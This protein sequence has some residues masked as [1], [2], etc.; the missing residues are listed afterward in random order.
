MVFKVAQ[1]FYVDS[2]A[3][4]SAPQCTISSVTLF[5]KA[6][7]LATNNKSGIAYP[8]LQ[9]HLFPC[10]SDGTPDINT[11]IP[12]AVS[13]MEFNGITASADASAAT[14]FEFLKPVVVPTNAWYVVLVSADGDED[15][16]LWS[17]TEGEYYVGTNTLSSGANSKN[18]GDYYEYSSS[19]EP[20][21][22]QV[23][24]T[25]IGPTQ[26]TSISTWKPLKDVDLKFKVGVAVNI[27]VE[28]GSIVANSTNANTGNNV[29]YGVSYVLPNEPYEFM[30]Y[31]KYGFTSNNGQQPLDLIGVKVYQETP[32]TYG[33]LTVQSGNSTILSSNNINFN[34]LFDPTTAE[35]P[36][37]IMKDPGSGIVALRQIKEIQSNTQLVVIGDPGFTSNTCN[38]IVSPVAEIT[39][40]EEYWYSGNWW[41][42][43]ILQNFTEHALDVAVLQNSNANSTVRF[44]NNH[45]TSANVTA[46]GSGYSN[47]DYITVSCGVSSSLNATANIVTSNIG[48]ITGLAFANA[49]YG[50]INTASYSIFNANGAASSG[51]GATLT[52]QTGQNIKTETPTK[53]SFANVVFDNFEAHWLTPSIII[54]NSVNATVDTYQ[55]FSYYVY[56][57]SENT[58]N[59]LPTG[60]RVTLVGGNQFTPLDYNDGRLWVI[61]SRSNDVVFANTAINKTNPT[62]RVQSNTDIGNTAG[63]I[64]EYVIQS[65]NVFTVPCIITPDLHM[66]QYVI[67][68]DATGENKRNG[69][70]LA[71][72]VSTKI[73]F[74]RSREAEDAVVVLRARR[75]AG[76]D[77]KVYAKIYN[78]NDPESF[79]DKDWSELQV[80][81]NN[82][83]VTTSLTDS[84]SLVEFH[85]GFKPYPNSYLVCNTAVATTLNSN[86]VIGAVGSAFTG[87]FQVSDVVKIS[88]PLFPSNYQITTIQAV[89]NNSQIVLNDQVANNSIVGTN[90]Q[91]DLIGRVAN[92]ANA[93]IGL[94]MQAFNNGQNDNIVRYYNSALSE[95]DTYETFAIKIVLLSSKRNIVPMIEDVRALG[96]TT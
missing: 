96:V 18:I 62:T 65:N 94:P 93:E 42:G 15:F 74:D 54:I 70:A 19:V 8:G 39:S 17:C 64:S 59:K 92:G 21:A 63:S 61:P 31:D 32:V 28:P 41:N 88:S 53:A 13:A 72:H 35:N 50:F 23:S 46:P 36:Y 52:F 68:N 87:T 10:K 78:S 30:V 77:I 84:S 9:V 51:T 55:H 20:F 7:P 49:G 4:K 48:A 95:F 38:F 45:V 25:T 71:K 3:L 89:T 16:T 43:T 26:N 73:S 47:T 85:Y 66:Y 11:P 60:D 27:D 40:V 81:S 22:S 34:T 29:T 57:G 56:P 80:T 86:V 91:L 33:T 2:A 1:T 90:M 24:A 14:V 67:N 44:V 83:S 58:L 76:T 5:V 6:K 75:P 12:N 37:L 69:N 82:A 79:D